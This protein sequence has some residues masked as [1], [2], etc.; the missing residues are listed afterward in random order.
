MISF[1]IASIGVGPTSTLTMICWTVFSL[2]RHACGLAPMWTVTIGLTV[3]AATLSLR[4]GALWVGARAPRAPSL[5]LSMHPLH[6]INLL[7]RAP[8]MLLVLLLR[9]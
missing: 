2:L 8:L 5:R 3:G 6:R 7:G 9:P 4:R 1:L